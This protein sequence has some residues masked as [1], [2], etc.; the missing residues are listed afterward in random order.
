MLDQPYTEQVKYVDWEKVPDSTRLDDHEKIERFGSKGKEIREG[1]DLF[2]W[3]N[4]TVEREGFILELY[5]SHCQHSR[6]RLQ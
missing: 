5:C 6:P 4:Q 1:E 2:S 3:L